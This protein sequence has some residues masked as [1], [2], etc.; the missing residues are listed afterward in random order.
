MEL[1]KYQLFPIDFLKI[2]LEKKYSKLLYKYD[3]YNRSNNSM[4]IHILFAIEDIF[5]CDNILFYP[6]IPNH[7]N[8]WQFIINLLS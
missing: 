2:I 3:I 8:W 6:I 4:R 7:F 1:L 5:Q